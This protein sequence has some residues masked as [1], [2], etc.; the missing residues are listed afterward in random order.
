MLGIDE[1]FALLQTVETHLCVKWK[2]TD[3]DNTPSAEEMAYV[4]YRSAQPA[5]LFA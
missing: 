1:E 4:Q 5:F 2:T 3:A